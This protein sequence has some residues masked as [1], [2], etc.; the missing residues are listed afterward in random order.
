MGVVGVPKSRLKQ[1]G[2][3]VK[4]E[5]FTYKKEPDAC[6]VARACSRPQGLPPGRGLGAAA[7]YEPWRGGQAATLHLLAIKSPPAGG[8]CAPGCRDQS[9][10]RCLVSL[11]ESALDSGH[12]A[13]GVRKHLA[14]DP[15]ALRPGESQQEHGRLAPRR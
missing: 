6:G 4:R 12:P 1:F 15:V 14:E 11:Q 10:H 13:A 7:R 2:F 5:L 3:R 8:E 9:N